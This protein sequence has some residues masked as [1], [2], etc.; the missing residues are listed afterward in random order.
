M[1]GYIKI[2]KSELKVKEYELYKG[3][4]CSLC[5]K[6]GKDYG[7]LGRLTLNYDFTFFLLCRMA[8]KNSEVCFTKSHCSF[9]PR[10]KCVCCGLDNDELDYTAALS[11]M[12]AFY[13]IKDDIE[14]EGFIK[15]ILCFILYP[16]FKHKFKKAKQKYPDFFPTL[17]NEILKQ[18]EL[19]QKSNISIDE[20]ADPS[21]K[22]LGMSFSYGFE[23]E[24]KD[25]AYSFGYSI[26][27]LVYI[28][29]AV[30]DFEKDKKSG[31]F[32]AFLINE[33]KYGQNMQENMKRILSS[34]AD[35]NAR[36]YESLPIKRFKNI[37]DN[38]V[39]YGFEDTINKIFD[40]KQ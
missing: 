11:I 2:H 12:F 15:K 16:F 37:T 20:C 26:G 19:E 40:K 29:D 1:F 33:E 9:N 5:K 24:I 25:K 22:V 34:T 38:I 8:I 23:E 31:K 35:E 30:D 18:K 39:Y 32:N 27:R 28:F 3:L 10:K 17:E 21:A 4:Y 6:L 14:D 13:K 36:I 7:F